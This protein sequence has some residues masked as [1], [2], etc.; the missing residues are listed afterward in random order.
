MM[1]S[2]G[3]SRLVVQKILNHVETGVTSVDDRHSYDAEMKDALEKMGQTTEQD[4]VEPQSGGKSRVGL[5]TGE[6]SGFAG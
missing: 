3:I 6:W 1:T 5:T 4:R 2:M